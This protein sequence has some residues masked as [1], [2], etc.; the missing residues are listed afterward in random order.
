MRELGARLEPS[1]FKRL[2]IKV[3]NYLT[4]LVKRLQGAQ[5]PAFLKKHWKT[6]TVRVG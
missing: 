4:N 5:A 1:T 6:S 2:I 3:W